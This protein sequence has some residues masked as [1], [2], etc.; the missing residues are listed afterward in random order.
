MNISSYQDATSSCDMM[1]C[2]Q[3][4]CILLGHIQWIPLGVSL[5]VS[6]YFL[7]GNRGGVGL[8]KREHRRR[9]WKEYKEGD[10]MVRM[11]KRE[12]QNKT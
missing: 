9:I 8:G 1:I 10:T 6:V 5:F 4:Y 3:S 11:N 2:A 7:M 12:K